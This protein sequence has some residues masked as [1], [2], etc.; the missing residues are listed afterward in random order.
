MILLQMSDDGHQDI[1]MRG[2]GN[3]NPD[4]HPL[5][6]ELSDYFGGNANRDTIRR[7]VLRHNGSGTNNGTLANRNTRHDDA[8][9]SDMGPVLN[10]DGRILQR[11]VHHRHAHLILRQ[12][13][14][15]AKQLA[16]SRHPYIL[17]DGN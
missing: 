12:I 5:F 3:V 13:P 8:A 6:Y 16:A 11:K 4:F 1:D 2:I 14:L 7:D 10:D 9:D 15:V 17:P